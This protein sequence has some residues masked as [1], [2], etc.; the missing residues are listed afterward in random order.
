MAALG[1]VQPGELS[2][3]APRGYQRHDCGYCKS[4]DG[5]A[6]YYASSTSVR[7]EEYE[8]LLNRGW[9]RSGTLYYKPNLERSCCPHYTMRL[10]ASSYK[11]RRDQ[12]KALNRWNK[13]VLGQEYIRSAARLC[14]KTREEKKYRRNTFDLRQRVHEAE[15]SQLKRP[16]D[17]KTKRPIEPAHKFEVNIEADSLSLMKHN[18]FLNYQMTVHKDPQ[19]RWK[20]SDYKRFLCSGIKRKT[21]RQGFKEQKLG[22]YHQCYRLDGE[23]IAVGVLDLLPTG[24]S[25]VYIYYDPQYEHWEIGKLSAMREIALA[26]EGHHQY[27]YM[28]Y[29]IHSCPKMRYKGAFRPQ[30]L[31]DP[32]SLSWDPLDSYVEK[33]NK[34]RYVSLSRDRKVGEEQANESRDDGFILP[35]EEE[36]SLFDIHMPGVLTLEELQAQIDLDHWRLL[37]HNTLVEMTDLVAWEKSNIKEPHAIKGIVAELAAALGPKVVKNSAVVLFAS[38]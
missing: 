20:Q 8:E 6:S 27:Y 5:S 23:L 4:A 31:L 13:F 25:S 22:S 36:M 19:E 34:R 15:Y 9:R 10:E 18:I 14:P 17:P 37:V 7:V 24:V 21:V 1:E 3:F 33:L 16:V 30:Y 29:Y 26:I 11:P 28:G 32:E 38:G 35:G 2:F 12:K